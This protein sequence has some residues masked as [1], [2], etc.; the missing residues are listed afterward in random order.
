MLTAASCTMP[1]APPP[2]PHALPS[3]ATS[4]SLKP[5]ALPS[6]SASPTAAPSP[7]TPTAPTS[8]PPSPSGPAEGVGDGLLRDTDRP[9]VDAVHRNPKYEVPAGKAAIVIHREPPGVGELAWMH[10]ERSFCLAVIRDEKA[11][12][13]CRILPT[14]W[15]RV[16]IRL[17]TEGGSYTEQPGGRVRTVYFAIVDGG[18]GPYG[19]AGSGDPASGMGPIR[20]A[21]A[22][23]ASGRTLSLVTYERPAGAQSPGDKEICSA[24]NAIC[25][26]ALDTYSGER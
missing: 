2:A 5:Q 15:P 18:H 17:V 20:D 10:D 6:P 24:D 8:A 3:P 19:Y 1:P 25:F 23:F 4:P 7:V 14:A 26:P 22:V 12:T 13:Q 21:T 16:G 11:T 9:L